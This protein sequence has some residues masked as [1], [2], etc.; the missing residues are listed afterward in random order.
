M[1]K[2]VKTKNGYLFDVNYFITYIEKEQE[3]ER[4]RE[5]ERDREMGECT[6][7]EGGNKE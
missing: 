2:S 4:G 6:E 7:R 5:G 3:I 1:N